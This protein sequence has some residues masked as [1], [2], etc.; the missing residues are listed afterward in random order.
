MI[1][2]NKQS[3]VAY[4]CPECGMWVKGLIGIFTLSADMVR[5]KCPC[6][7][8]EMTVEKTNDGKIRTVVPCFICPKPHIYTLSGGM[9]FTRELFA[10]PCAYSGMDICY[11]GD[12]KL[13]DE[14]CNEGDRELSELMGDTGYDSFKDA[15]ESAEDDFL[16]DPQILDIVSFVIRDLDEAG[17]I[18]C[19]CEDGE[20]CYSIDIAGESIVVRCSECGASAIIPVTSTITA[21]AFLECTHLELK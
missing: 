3:Y 14:A 8:S 7:H 11:L 19:R 16:S 10:L 17:E 1:L 18:K 5:L 15:R 2:E 20:G 9:F 12:E 6:G 13:V 4:R 21:N